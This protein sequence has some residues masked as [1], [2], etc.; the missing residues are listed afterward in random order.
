MRT[1]GWHERERGAPR[2]AHTTDNRIRNAATGMRLLCSCSS[3]CTHRVH[4]PKEEGGVHARSPLR[5]CAMHEEGPPWRSLPRGP[6]AAALSGELARRRR[7]GHASRS[8]REWLIY[9]SRSRRRIPRQRERACN[10]APA[11]H[12]ASAKMYTAS[13]RAAY[14]PCSRS[15]K[16]GRG[17]SAMRSCS[18]W[19]RRH[20]AMTTGAEN[21]G[22]TDSA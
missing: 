17:T 3:A 12:K 13:D 4:K 10:S 9:R 22:G 8:T 15:A 19:N 7:P 16:R 18:Q 1:A 11:M 6:E 20:P 2:S 21:C 5:C 14:E